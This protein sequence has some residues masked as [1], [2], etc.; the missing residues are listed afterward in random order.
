VLV[1]LGSVH[2][3]VSS[4]LDQNR[5]EVIEMAGSRTGTASIW[6][7]ARKIQRLKGTY[8][9]ADMGTRLSPEFVDCVDALIACTIAIL[10]TDDHVLQID[11][12]APLG[13]EDLGPP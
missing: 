11:S 3:I 9:A 13:P 6:Q 2:R 1:P 10:A 4:P 8:G 12:T 5:R 7:A